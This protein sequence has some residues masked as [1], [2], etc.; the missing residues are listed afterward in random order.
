MKMPKLA[1]M[2]AAIVLTTAGLVAV[3]PSGAWA[4]PSDCTITFTAP[5]VVQSYC[6]SG[7]GEHKIHMTLRHFLP[8]VGL[9]P[10][11]GQWA[12]VGGVSSTGYPPHTI[13]NVWIEKRG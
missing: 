7:T 11:E 4:V 13:E 2:F 8:E 9:I 12:P 5:R 6:T 10:V 3:T 1:P